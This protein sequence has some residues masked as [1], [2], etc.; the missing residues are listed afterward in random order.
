MKAQKI[1]FVFLMVLP[2]IFASCKKDLSTPIMT[3]KSIAS[4]V[5]ITG[6][7]LD[8]GV[9]DAD[10]HHMLVSLNDVS[11]TLNG[12]SDA[13]LAGSISVDFYTNSDAIIPDGT[14]TFSKDNNFVPFTFKSATIVTASSDTMGAQ[15]FDLADGTITL[16]R[17]GIT[18]SIS[19]DGL[20]SP[21]NNFQGAF[22]GDLSYSDK[23]AS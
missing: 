13:P 4:T 17:S 19:F 23:V 6:S 5:P 18:Y 1:S 2:L 22:S 14:Y 12:Q 10:V 7:I 8:L 15:T 11:L 16:T 21:G 3:S 20:I 9:N